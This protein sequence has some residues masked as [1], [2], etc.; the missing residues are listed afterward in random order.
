MTDKIINICKDIDVTPVFILE[1]DR[2]GNTVDNGM[3]V[4]FDLDRYVLIYRD[5]DPQGKYDK[6]YKA[7]EHSE[8]LDV[9]TFDINGCDSVDRFIVELGGDGYK[10]IWENGDYKVPAFIKSDLKR[11]SLLVEIKEVRKY[12]LI[13]TYE[14]I[15]KYL[16]SSC[17][18]KYHHDLLLKILKDSPERNNIF[19]EGRYELD[20]VGDVLVRFGENS[21]IYSFTVDNVKTIENNGEVSMLL[22]EKKVK[23]KEFFNSLTNNVESVLDLK[24]GG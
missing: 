21:I 20:K 18:I 10:V 23:S 11:I 15:K 6:I 16:N 9:N 8:E 4:D 2:A 1:T 7:F 13:V 14:E 22:L 17:Q 12:E 19:N 24:I 5:N 3:G